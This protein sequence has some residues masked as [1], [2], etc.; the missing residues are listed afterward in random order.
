[1][2]GHRLP[3]Q[4]HGGPSV[5]IGRCGRVRTAAGRVVAGCTPASW[6]RW[7]SCRIVEAPRGTGLHLDTA[8]VWRDRFAHGGL[9]A[10]ADRKRC[11]RPARITPAQVAEAK[12]LACQ[13]PAETGV[14]LS[15]WSCPEP[16]TELPA[17][18]MTDSVSASTVR[19]WLRETRLLDRR[20][21]LLPPGTEGHRPSDPRRFR[22]RSWSTPRCT[23]RCAPPG[24]TRSRSSS[25]SSNARSS[26]PTTSPT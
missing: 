22:M 24:R 16:A 7:P 4:R 21:R 10:L 9:P 14:P 26:D 3:G 18:G 11:G 25:R 17:R 19:R 12:A 2:D 8:R 15:R 23:P 20:Q 13:V 1:M 6:G 5:A